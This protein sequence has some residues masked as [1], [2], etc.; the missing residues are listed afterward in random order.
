MTNDLIDFIRSYREPVSLDEAA[1][2]LHSLGNAGADWPRASVQDWRRELIK[3][4]SDGKLSCNDGVLSVPKV[5][6]MQQGNLFEI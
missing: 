5:E 3:F 6:T 2:E 1:I 4:V